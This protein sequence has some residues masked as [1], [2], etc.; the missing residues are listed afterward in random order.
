MGWI[1]LSE[2]VE[3]TVISEKKTSK[4]VCQAPFIAILLVQLWGNEL[5]INP[6]AASVV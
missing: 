1:L 5:I 3:N 4:V 6:A 2:G